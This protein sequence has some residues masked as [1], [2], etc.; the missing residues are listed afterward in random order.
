MF[1][2]VIEEVVE[3]CGQ[4]YGFADALH[5][6][7]LPDGV[8][9]ILDAYGS[10][11]HIIIVLI[12]HVFASRENASAYSSAYPVILCEVMIVVETDVHGV[13]AG[14]NVLVVDGVAVLV[15]RQLFV[16]VG[17][18]EVRWSLK[19]RSCGGKLVGDV[20]VKNRSRNVILSLHH[21]H[22]SV[23]VV[24]QFRLQVLVTFNNPNTSHIKIIVFLLQRRRSES[25]TVTCAESDV[26]ARTIAHVKL[27]RNAR[28][29]TVRKIVITQC[30][31]HLQL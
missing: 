27:W 7:Q 9:R 17:V 23:E 6:R 19:V 13:L 26:A 22:R 14:W 3:S 29:L 10:F 28:I 8:S 16:G 31:N 1:W 18:C 20:A 30:S 24:T 2:A 21:F 15:L 4:R 11:A 25:H 12:L 5:E